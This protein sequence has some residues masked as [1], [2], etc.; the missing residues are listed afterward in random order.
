M[1]SVRRHLTKNRPGLPQ[2]SSETPSTALLVKGGGGPKT[3]GTR[4]ANSEWRR[5]ALSGSY[6]VVAE[7][8]GT[9]E[10]VV[11]TF[12]HTVGK[13][14]SRLGLAFFTQV[15][16]VTPSGC[17]C[18]C[19]TPFLRRVRC[20]SGSHTLQKRQ[21][22]F[23]YCSLFST[24]LRLCPRDALHRFTALS[25]HWPFAG[26]SEVSDW[27]PMALRVGTP[28]WAHTLSQGRDRGLRSPLPAAQ[29]EFDG[30]PEAVSSAFTRVL[31]GL[32]VLPDHGR[33]ELPKRP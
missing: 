6:K 24:F 27:Q 26:D 22:L 14:Q 32:S 13:Q 20:R 17:G 4:F 2:K 23:Q 10:I 15:H 30:F 25:G 9:R 28:E 33:L 31:A 21:R 16:V 1:I 29:Y 18:H 3:P 7:T 8:A 11:V 12:L 19:A 5:G